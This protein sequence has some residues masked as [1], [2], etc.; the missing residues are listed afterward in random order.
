MR[1][2]TEPLKRLHFGLAVRLLDADYLSRIR[3]RSFDETTNQRAGRTGLI[4]V[5]LKRIVAGNPGL[6]RILSSTG[7]VEKIVKTQVSQSQRHGFLHA[8]VCPKGH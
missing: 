6:A 2:W 1:G 7:L 8:A 4:L 5:G 3:E